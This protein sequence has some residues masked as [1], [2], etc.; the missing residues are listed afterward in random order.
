MIEKLQ[1]Y[2]IS[3]E[4]FV[5]LN[6]NYTLTKGNRLSQQA[7]K[8]LSTPSYIAICGGPLESQS[9]L[10]ESLNVRNFQRNVSYS[11]NITTTQHRIQQYQPSSL[12]FNRQHSQHISTDNNRRKRSFSPYITASNDSINN[13]DAI[14]QVSHPNSRQKTLINTFSTTSISSQETSEPL[15]PTIRNSGITFS[16]FMIT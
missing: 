2:D 4:E 10:N 3:L 12:L 7:Q 16:I 14:N 6:S 9:N 15:S 8:V 5:M 11:S 1:Q 13:F